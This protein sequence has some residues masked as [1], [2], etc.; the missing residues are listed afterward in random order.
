MD[1][2]LAVK[3]VIV[4]STVFLPG[5]LL[6]LFSCWHRAILKTFLTQPSIF[7]LPVFSHFTFVS[8]SKRCSGGGEEG[9]E[10]GCA[11]EESFITFSP[12]FTAANVGV[13]EL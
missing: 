8:N 7:L 12:K 9:G 2:N 6:D 11:E 10:F 5:F 4:V 1:A 13:R 3:A